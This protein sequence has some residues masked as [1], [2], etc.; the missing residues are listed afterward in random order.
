MKKLFLALTAVSTFLIIMTKAESKERKFSYI[1]VENGLSSNSVECIFQDKD[2]MMWFGTHDGLTMYDTY[3]LKTWRHDPNNKNSI[4]NNC[5]YIIYQ[6]TKGNLWIGTERGVYIFDKDSDSFRQLTPATENIIAHGITEDSKGRIWI[7]S[8]SNGIFRYDPHSGIIKN[9]KHSPSDSSSIKSDYC[10]KVIADA[11]GNIW[12]ISS[13]SYLYKYDE[14]SSSFKSILITDKKKNITERNVFSMCADWE[15]NLWLAGWDSGIFHYNV[16]TNTFTN[17]LTEA[18][19]PVLKGRIH[20]INELD[21]GN[22]YIGSDH[23]M[24]IYNVTARSIETTT[25]SIP[26]YGQLSDV[27]VYDIFKDREDGL[28]VAT[29]FGGVNYSNPNSANF[30]YRKCS[31]DSFKG[32]VISKFCE[33]SNK[34]I[35]IG[36]DDGGLFKYDPAKDEYADILIDPEVPN[37]NIH[38][39]L[40]DKGTLW[41]GTYAN[42]LYKA[43]TKSWKVEHFHTF[44]ADKSTI[45]SIYSLHKDHTGKIWIGTKTGIWYWT[46]R[47][48]F[49]CM[50]ELGYNSDV[51]EIIDDSKGNIYFAS[52]SKG[53]FKYTP[54]TQSIEKVIASSLGIDIPD[55]I[56]S[57]GGITN[58]QLLI[59]TT[60]RGLIKFDIN[61]TV[62]SE[63][64]IPNMDINNM[65][66]FHIINDDENIWLST[67]EGLL[68]YNPSL[69]I[70]NVFGREDGLRTDIFSCNS[71]IKAS[72]GRIYLGTNDGFNIFDPK[73]INLNPIAPNTVFTEAS[74]KFLKNGD[75]IVLRKGHEPFTIAFAALSY[76][77]PEKNHYRYTMKGLNNNLMKVPWKNNRVTFSNL[78]CGTY[79]FSVCSS[80][81]DGLWGKPVTATFT[82]KPYWYNCTT[83]KIIYILMSIMTATGIIM[84]TMAYYAQKKNTRAAKIAHLKERT[85]IETE[86][87]FFTNLAHE[88]RTPVML[89]NAPVNEISE[90]PDLPQKIQENITF[91]KKSSDKL[92]SLTNEILNFRK[93]SKDMK[94]TPEPIISLTRQISEEFVSTA[95]NHGITLCFISN[96]DENICASINSDAWS[97]IM[98]NLISNAIKFA[99]DKIEIRS[100]LHGDKLLIS[101]YDNGCGIAE[102]ERK[103]IFQAF[104]HYDKGSRIKTQGF[105]LGLS[106]TSMLAHKMGMEVMVESK[107]D[108]Y[109]VFTVTV[110]LTSDDS[111][112]PE[113][114]TTTETVIN[115]Y[116]NN[117]KT[118]NECKETERFKSVTVMIVD[119]DEDMRKYLETSLSD[120]Y[121]TFT[122]GNGEEALQ[123][124]KAGQKADLIVSDVIMPKMNG[125]DFCNNLKKDV[126]LAHIPI[127][128]LSTNSDIEL[129]MQSVRNGSDA[130][131]DKPVDISYL[132]VLIGSILQKRKSLWETFSKRPFLALP[133]IVDRDGVENQFLK[134]FS[135]LILKNLSKQDLKIEDLAEGMH[136]SRTV[137]F[138]KVKD[139]TGMTPN[140]FIKTVRLLKAAELIAQGKHKINEICWMVGFNTPSYFSK[141]FHEHFGVYPK[142]FTSKTH[143]TL[144]K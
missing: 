85:R 110:P 50:K 9:W 76:R 40:S 22:I 136:T 91:I 35:W 54:K 16:E 119:D 94:Q 82:I 39:L 140:N 62:A 132:K 31:N 121:I 106:I 17:H 107:I 83:A 37:L 6:D 51:I 58:D 124:L 65:T 29:Y 15:G 19:V 113:M 48:G 81:N 80:N 142:D 77:S 116:A 72:D 44:E 84:V 128:L 141:C 93:C 126:N 78:K 13:G 117:E 46:S 36:T 69:G 99:K 74:F 8:L 1:N 115:E 47:N 64:P 7:A 92:V 56:M 11:M 104:W 57:L 87:Q 4:G 3:T 10:P 103:N 135:N 67:N 122:A 95:K 114:K 45:Q 23:G 127:I 133:G 73:S 98:N 131:V 21:P 61:T 25:Y 26:M 60:G 53:L 52:I 24:S 86:L 63:V 28:W 34:K 43:D 120:T 111:L 138:Q 12:C 27:F 75:N 79:T 5:V 137:L 123:M 2:G 66:V 109:S 71:G 90:M 100:S 55:D 14:S 59:G 108:E 18:G 134:E 96:T 102:A 70:K 42:G 129:K 41:V 68:K 144:D 143:N 101:V 38:A 139:L 49:V 89:I 30:I 125:I 112:V 130:Y 20:T 88:I 97:K 33:D 105:G 118:N 32:R